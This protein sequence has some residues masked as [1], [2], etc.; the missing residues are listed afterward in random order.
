MEDNIIKEFKD[1]NGNQEEVE[2]SGESLNQETQLVVPN[3]NKKCR[4]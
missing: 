3:E 1:K 2:E 4:C